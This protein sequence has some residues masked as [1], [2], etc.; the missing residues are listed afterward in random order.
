[1]KIGVVGCGMVG[2]SAAFSLVMNGVGRDIV[3]VDLDR[4]RAE[5]EAND[6]S[7]EGVTLAL[8]HIVGGAGVIATI[9]LTL[10]APEQ[11]LLRRANRARLAPRPRSV[12]GLNR[13]LA[14]SDGCVRE[15]E[16]HERTCPYE[17]G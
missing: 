15:R 12:A 2:S 17:I 16:K 5:A 11:V 9:P 3:L 1:M 6:L 14:A 8:P 13:Q 7:R 4:K 10:D